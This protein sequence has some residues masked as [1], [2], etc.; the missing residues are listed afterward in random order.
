LDFQFGHADNASSWSK[1]LHIRSSTS[2]I[3]VPFALKGASRAR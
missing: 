2:M 1:R 3:T